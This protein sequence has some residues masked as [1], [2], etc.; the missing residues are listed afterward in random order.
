MLQVRSGDA[1][2][3]TALLPSSGL[4]PTWG[5]AHPYIQNLGRSGP[6]RFFRWGPPPQ[7][8]KAPR[9]FILQGLQE[10]PWPPVDLQVG[11][12]GLSKGRALSP[13]H[14][15]EVASPTRCAGTPGRNCSILGTAASLTAL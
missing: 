5:Q 3:V 6:L 7:G 11:Q 8:Q 10:L 12:V 2:E 1:G 4:T 15:C 9:P 13:P 14:F